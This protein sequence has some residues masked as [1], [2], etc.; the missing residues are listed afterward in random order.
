MAF[1]WMLFLVHM[2]R[3]GT[4]EWREL[5]SRILASN[6]PASF[7]RCDL[8]YFSLWYFS[9]AQIPTNYRSNIG[10]PV[11]SQTVSI[12]W[13]GNTLL[14]TKILI[15]VLPVA[16][17]FSWVSLNVCW[18]YLGPREHVGRLCHGIPS[19]FD[20]ASSWQVNM[21]AVA[22]CSTADMNDSG[23]KAL[24]GSLVW[25]LLHFSMESEYYF[26]P[27]KPELNSLETIW[28]NSAHAHTMMTSN[29]WI[30]E[31]Q[32]QCRYLNLFC[33]QF[34]RATLQ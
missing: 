18:R 16:A 15:K 33:V 1:N 7:S 27:A 3:L 31:N 23:V 22:A 6:W 28:L 14:P 11:S 19:V 21:F 4:V 9:V 20:I 13:S 8:M 2:H 26:N 34:G 29:E 30:W 32:Q 10:S 12:L 5:G 24:I 17:R 25:K